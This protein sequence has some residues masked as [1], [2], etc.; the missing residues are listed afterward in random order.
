MALKDTPT[1]S[2]LN[3]TPVSKNAPRPMSPAR[4]SS[5]T[6]PG[7][8]PPAATWAIRARTKPATPSAAVRSP[9]RT[10]PVGDNIADALLSRR[11]SE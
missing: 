2:G 3:R 8:P 5:A 6:G 1:R 4:T 7:T 10:P 9:R 11:A